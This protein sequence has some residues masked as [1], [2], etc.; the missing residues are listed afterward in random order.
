MRRSSAPVAST[1]SAKGAYREDHALSAGQLW[2]EIALK[3]VLCL[4]DD[5]GIIFSCREVAT[6]V[7]EKLPVVVMI[8]DDGGYTAMREYQ[9]KGYGPRY[10]GVDF[11]VRPGFVKLAES[12]GAKVPRGRGRITSV[13]PSWRPCGPQR[14]L[15]STS[16]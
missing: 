3:T 5:R 6:S 4:A 16:R 13:R 11:S 15:S 10:I 9:R 12:L 7:E 8:F 14:P 1:I 2:E